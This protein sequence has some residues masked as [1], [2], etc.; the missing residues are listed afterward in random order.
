MPLLIP[1]DPAVEARSGE[2]RVVAMSAARTENGTVATVAIWNGAPLGV[3]EV[4]LTN[5]DDRDRLV[6]KITQV[7]GDQY[8]ADLSRCLL[9]VYPDV[10]SGMRRGEARTVTSDDDEVQIAPWPA[11]LGDAAYIGLPGSIVKEIMPHTEADPAAV[12][13]SFLAMGGAYLGH[14]PHRWASG[15]RHS[16]ATFLLVIGDTSSGRKGSSLGHLK[17][18]FRQLDP[19]WATGPRKRM[20]VGLSTG[21]GLIAS[22]Q[23]ASAP[24]DGDDKTHVDTRDTDVILQEQR[25]VFIETEFA[26]VLRRMAQENNTLSNV[27]RQAWDG[28][29]LGTEVKK[30]PT[31]TAGSHVSVIGHITQA[32]ALRYLKTTD[33]QNGF[34]NRFLWCCSKR[35]KYLPF[36]GGVPDFTAQLEWMKDQRVRATGVSTTLSVQMDDAAAELWDSVY[37]SLVDRPPGVVGDVTCRAEAQVLRLALI[38]CFL[39]SMDSII[40]RPHVAAAL[41]VWRYCEDS[42]RWAF[43]EGTDTGDA[44][45]V[46]AALKAIHPDALSRTA[47]VDLFGRHAPKTRIDAALHALMDA[48]AVVREERARADGRP[49]KGSTAYRLAPTS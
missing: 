25:S 6:R 13:L 35:S 22:L 31:S 21:E 47:I 7:A 4:T 14:M 41:E 8:G 48:G 24:D 46:L 23:R 20:R 30:D 40:T 36:G 45:R 3:E 44:G 19:T 26:T 1:L 5:G 10:E 38:Y 28:E 2:I 18:F 33:Q 27:L 32:D 49:G 16:L 15:G 43:G 39:S 34:A 42:V 12:L 37:R 11:P 9:D 29:E 17:M